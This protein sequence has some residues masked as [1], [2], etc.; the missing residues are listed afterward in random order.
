MKQRTRLFTADSISMLID[1]L[2][3]LLSERFE[4]TR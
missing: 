4:N 2:D 3:E 1:S